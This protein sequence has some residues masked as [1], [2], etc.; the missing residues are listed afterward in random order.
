MGASLCEIGKTLPS[1]APVAVRLTRLDVFWS[2]EI[3]VLKPQAVLRATENWLL[4]V[5]MGFSSCCAHFYWMHA[6]S[7]HM[8]SRPAN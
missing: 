7:L 5:D 4:L 2:R 8:L 3:V 1:R 6:Q